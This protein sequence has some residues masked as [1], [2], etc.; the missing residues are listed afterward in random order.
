MS[1]PET[2]QDLTPNLHSVLHV[3]LNNLGSS[4]DLLRCVADF[5]QKLEQLGALHD[6]YEESVNGGIYLSILEPTESMEYRLHTAQ[7]MWDQYHDA[8]QYWVKYGVAPE[9]ASV[10]R[11]NKW[12]IAN[13]LPPGMSVTG[14]RSD[15][16]SDTA[17]LDMNGAQQ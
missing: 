9:G 14:Y 7:E 1:R 16:V 10:E 17:V 6:R 2:F 11:L 4:P 15:P 3:N 13:G 5:C 8:Y 12:A